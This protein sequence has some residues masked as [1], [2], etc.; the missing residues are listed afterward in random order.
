[1]RKGKGR[2]G[3]EERKR[4]QC[5][6]RMSSVQE[7]ENDRRDKNCLTEAPVVSSGMKRTV[8]RC[9]NHNR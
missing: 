4:G 9:I 6:H 2:V 8:D 3:E 7:D 1:M 5:L